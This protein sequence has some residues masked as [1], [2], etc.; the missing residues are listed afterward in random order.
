MPGSRQGEFRGLSVAARRA[1][2]D[3]HAGNRGAIGSMF[4][5]PAFLATRMPESGGVVKSSEN[6]GIDPRRDVPR[7]SLNAGRGRLRSHRC[8]SALGVTPHSHACQS[9]QHRLGN[10]RARANSRSASAAARSHRARARG[11]RGRLLALVPTLRARAG[12]SEVQVPLPA[13]PLLH[14]LLGL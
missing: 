12:E 7:R 10:G 8:E 14:E 2:T 11:G 9:S 1:A 4:D 6:Y 13:L 5:M 3:G